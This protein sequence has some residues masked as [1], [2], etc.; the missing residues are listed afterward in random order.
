[1][2]K[3]A[4]SFFIPMMRF[5]LWLLILPLNMTIYFGDQL[6]RKL[7]GFDKRSPFKR[8]GACKKSGV[9][10]EAIG[11]EVPKIW[12]KFPFLVRSFNVFERVVFGFHFEGIKDERMAV[13]TCEHFKE[14]RCSIH[15]FRHRICREYPWLTLTGHAH[16]QKGCGFS[17]E[18]K[19][20]LFDEHLDIK[21]NHK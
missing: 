5:Q 21:G 7:I 1:M 14:R 10:C 3:W 20:S 19:K 9:C 4:M 11:L 6:S 17:F 2:S 16:V 15:P 8:M 13:Y 18:K 12:I